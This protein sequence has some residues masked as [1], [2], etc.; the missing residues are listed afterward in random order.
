L[1]ELRQK[2]A[3]HLSDFFAKVSVEEERKRIEEEWKAFEQ[4]MER[5]RL[6]EE[7]EARQ[8]EENEQRKAAERE[9]R[10]LQREKEEAQTREKKLREKK[11]RKLEYERKKIIDEVRKTKLDEE[12]KAK[13][14]K[15]F[16][17]RERKRALKKELGVETLPVVV[18][19]YDKSK[20]FVGGIKLDDLDP[21]KLGKK[22]NA[23][24]DERVNNL[25]RLFDRFGTVTDRRVFVEKN[26]F[27]VTYAKSGMAKKALTAMQ[28]FESRKKIVEEIETQVKEKKGNLLTVPHSTFYVREPNVKKNRVTSVSPTKKGK[29]KSTEGEL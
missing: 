2:P 9:A 3:A 4:E 18:V 5:Q 7:E 27:F 19:D 22:Y 24:R 10:Q 13:S 28:N 25:L 20:I 12:Q 23:V 8:R 6:K 29:E 14:V 11:K 26:H 15:D 16:Q 1:E 17:E 21:A